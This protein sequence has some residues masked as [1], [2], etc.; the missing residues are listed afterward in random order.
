MAKTKT[1]RGHITVVQEARFTLITED[2][3]GMLFTLS[4]HADLDADALMRLHHS[5]VTVLVTFRGEPNIDTAQAL[6]V[7]PIL[8]EH[9]RSPMTHR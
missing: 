6:G 4:H 7:Q 2:G 3:N 1:A 9:Q 8:R 5:H